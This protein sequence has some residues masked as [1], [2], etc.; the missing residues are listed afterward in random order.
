MIEPKV[1]GAKG[2]VP[3]KKPVASNKT[4]RSRNFMARLYNLNHRLSSHKVK[5]PANI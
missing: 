2:T 3:T 1:P 5:Y 4:A